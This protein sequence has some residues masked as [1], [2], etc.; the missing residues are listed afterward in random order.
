MIRNNK[1]AAEGA[2]KTE[3]V[4]QTSVFD[5]PGTLRRLGGDT[6]LLADLVQLYEEDSPAL[7]DRLHKGVA[8][9]RADEVRHAAHSLRGLAANFGASALTQ[10]L[11]QLEDAAMHNRFDEADSLVHEASQQSA[12]LQATLT[13]HRH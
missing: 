11:L 10:S 3:T 8:A 7:F 2:Q 5:L 6:A 12:K 1:R 9:Q 13:V 4:P